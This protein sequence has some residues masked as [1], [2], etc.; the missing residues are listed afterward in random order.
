MFVWNT[1]NVY[2]SWL[3]L[4]FY[5]C[6]KEHLQLG[7][8]QAVLR[9]QTRGALAVANQSKPYSFCSILSYNDLTYIPPVGKLEN[10]VSNN[11]IFVFSVLFV[12]VYIIRVY[13]TSQWCVVI[14]V[15]NVN[16]NIGR[17][18][19]VVNPLY[20]SSVGDMVYVSF[21]CIQ[22]VC[23]CL[24]CEAEINVLVL[25]VSAECFQNDRLV[26]SGFV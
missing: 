12:Y 23:V 25:G 4:A 15:G 10:R 21:V 16:M 19:D 18:W 24:C 13:E 3:F 26:L 7:A 9:A 6:L 2:F 11:S 20:L 17:W 5:Y 1:L 8:E 22:C 14:L